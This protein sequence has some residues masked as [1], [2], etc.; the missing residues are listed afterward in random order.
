MVPP[1]F[2]YPEGGVFVSQITFSMPVKADQPT[3]VTEMGM[4]IEEK[5][6]QL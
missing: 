5:P 6:L 2:E 3:L 1:A 4:V